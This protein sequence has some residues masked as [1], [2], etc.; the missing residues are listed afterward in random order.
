MLIS[1][2]YSMYLDDI[3]NPKTKPPVGDEW[4]VVR[5]VVDA[6]SIIITMR[7]PSHISFDHDLGKDALTGYDLA[8]KLVEMDVEGDYVTFPRNFTYNVHSANP[9]GRDNII[10]LL[11]GY[12]KFKEKECQKLN[13][14]G[15]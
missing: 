9:V 1:R 7:Y 6:L 2:P 14:C 5:S 8:K 13:L 11:D 4:V 3:R 10:G 15:E 12:F